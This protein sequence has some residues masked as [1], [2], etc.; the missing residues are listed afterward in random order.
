M[1]A[2]MGD[3]L[4]VGGLVKVYKLRKIRARFL[5]VGKG[6]TYME[7]EKIKMSPKMLDWN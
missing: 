1:A 6:F 4:C 7:G 2:V 3:C 5:T